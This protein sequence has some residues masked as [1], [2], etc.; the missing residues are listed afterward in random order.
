MLLFC[1]LSKFK[2]SHLPD[3]PMP[4]HDILLCDLLK[5]NE[6]HQVSSS[7]SGPD[8]SEALLIGRGLL[9]SSFDFWARLGLIQLRLWQSGT[10]IYL[11]N[12]YIT[13]SI[14]APTEVMKNA[15]ERGTL[16]KDRERW[17][18]R[19]LVCFASKVGKACCLSYV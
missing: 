10:C 18:V 2:G 16:K 7:S 11:H 8:A 4:A 9:A 6:I 17:G 5:S 19:P 14:L 15:K 13:E 1:C 3:Q 12:I